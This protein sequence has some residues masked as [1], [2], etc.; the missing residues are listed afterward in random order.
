MIPLGIFAKTFPRPTVEAVLDEV[1]ALELRSV[2]FNF[3]C[4]G[5]PTL[6][7]TIEPSLVERIHAA[8]ARPGIEITAVSG[9]FNLIDS[10]RERRDTHL[11]RLGVLASACKVLETSIV[12]L[13]T[14]T[15]DSADMWRAHPDNSGPGAW[16]EMLES[17]TL[18]L[19]ITEPFEVTLAVEPE[20]G[21]VMSDAKKARKLLDEIRSPRLRVLFDAA[22]VLAGKP[23]LPQRDVLAEAFELVGSDIALAHGKE[24]VRDELASRIPGHGELDWD[25]YLELLLRSGYAAPLVLH[26]FDEAHAGEAVQ[27]VRGKLEQAAPAR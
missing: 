18:A 21:N 6:P 17:V 2:Q 19:W 13:S 24:F 4:A 14:G 20:P 1:A 27:F 12:T 22:N 26:G 8:A 3:T 25:L 5:L 11:R 23:D 15:R 16:D 10:D 9:T 7:E